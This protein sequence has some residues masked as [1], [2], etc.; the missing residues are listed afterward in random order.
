[1]GKRKEKSKLK[2]SHG[3]C[4]TPSVIAPLLMVLPFFIIK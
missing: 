3:Q 4:A 2:W 1:M